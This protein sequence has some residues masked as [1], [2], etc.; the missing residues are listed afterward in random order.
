VRGVGAPPENLIQARGFADGDT[1]RLERFENL[2]VELENLGYP[3]PDYTKEDLEE[4]AP[5]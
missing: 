5:R 2:F 1:R 4:D 3:F